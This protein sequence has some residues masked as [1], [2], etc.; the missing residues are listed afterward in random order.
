M[1]KQYFKGFAV[2]LFLLCAKI[3]FSQNIIQNGNFENGSTDWFLINSD[4]GA[5]VV[6][7]NTVF[8][9]GSSSIKLKINNITS[10]ITAGI[11]QS[12]NISSN[13]TYFFSYAIKTDNVNLFAFPYFKFH[14]ETDSFMIKS[15]VSSRTKDWTIYNLR[16]TTPPNVNK[17]DF[18]ILLTGNTGTVWVDIINFSEVSTI[19]LLSFMVDCNTVTDTFNSKLLSTNS[20]PVTPTSPNNLTAKFQE[21]GINGVRTHDIYGSCDIH[22]IFPDFTADPLNPDS[23]DFTTTDN[24][25]Q[26]I[27]NSGATPLYRLGETY[28]GTPNLFN[29]PSDFD[30]WATICLQIVKH[31]NAGWNN[32][33]YYNIKKWEIWNEPD[34]YSYWTGTSQQFYNLYKKTALKIKNFDQHLKIGAAGFSSIN[35][36]RFLDSFL[37][38]I[39]SDTVPIDFISYHF[40]NF[41]NPYYYSVQQQDLQTLL[42]KYGLSN[43]E[44]DLTEWNSYEY[45]AETTLTEYGRDDALSAA[46]TA[47]GLYYLQNS[48]LTDAYRYRTDEYFFGLFR[49]N[50]SYS[51]SGLA[52]NAVGNYNKNNQWLYTAGSD[53][54]GAVCFAG[55]SISDDDFSIIVSN[56]NKPS[57]GYSVTIQNLLQNYNYKITRIDKNKELIIVDSGKVS[58]SNNTITSAVSFP[59]VD[60][61]TFENASLGINNSSGIKSDI[62]LYP[63]PTTG[64]VNILKDK[65][66]KNISVLIFTISGEKILDFRNQTKIDINSLSAGIYFI[67]IIADDKIETKKIIKIK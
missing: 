43:I 6:I 36:T 37:D 11:F 25:I 42:S 21:I 49:N 20:S 29:P 54:S 35:N 60:L 52:F 1:K 24:V 8:F 48:T 14:N 45:N 30:K 40:Y 46:L 15:Y 44:T 3:M 64:I 4:T 51:Y 13:T 57:S 19:G 55:K 9:Q 39:S 58:P 17:L 67:K 7:D 59:Y 28:D 65:T 32:G 34:L 23:Y 22:L 61:I 41:A 12:L 62:Y 33:F 2:I 66:Y 63:N 53:S 10:N 26:S 5:S 47:S 18:F 27:I 16:I 50:G 31:Y 56:P 38:S